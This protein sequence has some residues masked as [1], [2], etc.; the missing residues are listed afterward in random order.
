V[1]G[2]SHVRSRRVQLDNAG[3]QRSTLTTE[4]PVTGQPNDHHFN[5]SRFDPEMMR[6][7]LAALAAAIAGTEDRV[8]DT[9]ERMA[10]THPEDAAVLRARAAQARQHATAE[11]SRAATFSAH[12]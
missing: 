6:L 11:R 3:G 1:G 12:H 8:A 7:R 2:I 5:G 10:L 9:L 4:A